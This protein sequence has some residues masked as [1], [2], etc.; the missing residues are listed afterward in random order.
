MSTASPLC[1]PEFEQGLQAR[2]ERL[3]ALREAAREAHLSGRSALQIASL[4]SVCHSAL[5]AA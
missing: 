4:M 5:T 2:K 1:D 3:R